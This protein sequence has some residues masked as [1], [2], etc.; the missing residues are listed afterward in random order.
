MHC[1]LTAPGRSVGVLGTSRAERH[2][3]SLGVRPKGAE[4]DRRNFARQPGARER[5]GHGPRACF[6]L[7]SSWACKLQRR[8]R[9]L[10]AKVSRRLASSVG[11]WLKPSLFAVTE[12]MPVY[13]P[14]S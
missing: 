11:M 7:N 2:R 3:A 10:G 4:A 12:Y 9:D 6:G 1:T 13:C 5:N 8:L 14:G